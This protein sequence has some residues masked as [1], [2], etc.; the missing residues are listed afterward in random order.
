MSKIKFDMRSISKKVSGVI[1]AVKNPTSS[2]VRNKIT[3]EIIKEGKA[4]T[5]QAANVFMDVLFKAIES[6]GLT[7]DAIEAVSD[8]K[9]APVCY[10]GNNRFTVAVY[11]DGDLSRPSLD[12]ARY[13][14]ISNIVALLNNG[15]DHTMHAVLGEWKGK[16]TWSKTHIVGAHFVEKAV[17]DYDNKYADKYRIISIKINGI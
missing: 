15:V 10:I 1:R 12:E 6:S 2:R 13:G 4:L 9:S 3:P 14:Q 7:A 8:I 17:Q 11:F 5:E 16:T